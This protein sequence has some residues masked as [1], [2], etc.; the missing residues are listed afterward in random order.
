ML[1]AS[2]EQ[3]GL[4]GRVLGAGQPLVEA[5]EAERDLLVV[6][7][8]RVEDRRVQVADQ[9]RVLG[10]VVAEGIGLAVA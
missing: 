10:D 6:H 1:R 9:H 5:L 7:A 3:P 4:H 8:Q 2:P